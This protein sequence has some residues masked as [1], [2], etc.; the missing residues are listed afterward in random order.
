MSAKIKNSSTKV[1]L[2]SLSNEPVFLRFNSGVTVHIAPHQISR[3]IMEGDIWN[4]H[5]IQKLL[6]RGVLSEVRLE[7][8][9]KK[10]KSPKTA[11]QKEKTEVSKK[12]SQKKKTVSTKDKN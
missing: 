3:E 8:Q 6:D 4:N 11:S 9:K 2:K 12:S 10:I 1:S 5:M 7:S